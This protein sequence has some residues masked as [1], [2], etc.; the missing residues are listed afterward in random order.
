MK[1][2][3]FNDTWLIVPVYNEGQVVGDVI[4]QALKTFPNI[5][6][7]DDC[8]RDNSGAAALAGG[9]VVLRHPVNLGQGAALQ[10]GLEFA[11]AQ[12]Q[13]KYFVTFDSDGQHQVSDAAAMVERLRVEPLDVL[14][15]SRFLDGR[16][17]ADALKKIILRMAAL[18]ERIGTGVKLTDAHNGLRALNLNAVSKIKITQ[19]RMAHASEIVSLI[20]Q[21]KL[22]Y[23]EHPVHILYT[24]YSRAK[25]Q[26]MWN[27]I[28][29]LGELFV[30]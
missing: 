12:P 8:S 10:T 30:K 24:D 18:F 5:V 21:H 17:N 14:L 9:A 20:G 26:S 23:A 15:G 4:S 11:A 1:Q 25:G 19:N 6:C 29:I 2:S 22:R 16:T 28:N 7:V 3:N 13:A 27:S